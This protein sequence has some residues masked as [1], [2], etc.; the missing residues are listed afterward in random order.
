MR[1][2][3]SSLIITFTMVGFWS[4]HSRA[5]NLTTLVRFCQTPNCADGAAPNGL[6][7]D[8]SGNLFGTT[9][10]G[11][12]DGGGFSGGT[13]FEIIKTTE[14]YASTP[15]TLL[16]FCSLPNCADGAA[17]NGVTVDANGNVLGTTSEGGANRFT[18][19]T[20]F[21][22]VKTTDG[23]ASNPTTL[24]SFCSLPNCA[25]GEQPLAGLIADGNGNLFGTTAGGGANGGGTV[26]E[27]VKTTDG[28]ASTPTILVSFCSLPNCAD[29]S[30]PT[31]LMIDPNGNLFG[32]TALSGVNSGGTVFE[33]VKTVDGYASTP[34]TLV[35]FCSLPNCGDGAQPEA[36]L[37]ADV[38]GNLFGTTSGGGANGG[39]TVFEI[40]E[41]ADGYATTPTTLVSFCSLPNCTDG[42]EPFAGLIADAKG[43][44]FG[45]TLYGGTGGNSHP[46][47][48]E[49]PPGGG[50]V[51][52]IIKTAD[53]YASTPT[54]L[55]S[56]CGLANCAD[57][58]GPGSVIADANGNLFGTTSSGTGTVFELTDT[59][60]VV[61]VALP[62]SEVFTIASGLAYSRVSQTF[63]G[64]VTITNVSR[65]PI[66]GP[67][68][69]LFGSLTA[70]TTLSNAQ[71]T[72]SGSP[73]LIVPG[74]DNLSDGQSASVRVEFQNPSFGMIDFTPV[75]YS[76]SLFR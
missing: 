13:V 31:G 7:F 51:F 61:P 30:A 34:T 36:G 17:P 65:N 2:I 70:G 24:V 76:G 62:P 12:A 50:T 16:S 60:F 11:G 63:H 39:G 29:G 66:S 46:G 4:S 57:G 40:V 43:N 56:F 44:L 42:L 37:I 32:T 9:A 22:I 35:N 59:G 6:T 23:Y 8:A 19:G 5:A 52:E 15:T 45:T 58:L 18:A 28:Y 71:G 21:E 48:P 25:D 26:F 41:T 68:S 75:V 1:K 69:I 55:Y 3:L 20:V 74:I 53:G 54:V 27:I 72:F 73:F 49:A 14:G 38:N 10:N 67:F 47:D 33:I 64:T